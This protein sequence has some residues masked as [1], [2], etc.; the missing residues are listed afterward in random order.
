MPGRDSGAG[1]RRGSAKRA[2][3]SSLYGTG[4]LRLV[5]Q[6]RWRVLADRLVCGRFVRSGAARRGR[7][8]RVLSNRRP[9]LG[10]ESV[11]LAPDHL[12]GE[13][14]IRERTAGFAGMKQR[15]LAEGGRLREADIARDDGAKQLV[16]EVRDQLRAHLVGEVVARVEHGA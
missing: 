6:S 1:A 3:E 8:R 4:K 5:A 13:G 9:R 14:Q 11:L 10:G 16:A 7:E 12:P 2:T 15:R